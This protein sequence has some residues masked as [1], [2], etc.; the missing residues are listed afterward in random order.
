MRR[1]L[2]S[3]L[4]A[5][6]FS[7]A[8]QA[9]AA[10]AE[11]LALVV[12]DGMR[13][14]YMSLASMPN[15]KKLIGDGVYYDGAWV[16]GVVNNTPPSHA[17]ISTGCFTRTHG[18]VAFTWKDPA[19]NRESNLTRP[20]PIENGE[21][22]KVISDHHVPSIAKSLRERYPDARTVAAGAHKFHA[23]AG[24]AGDSADYSIFIGGRPAGEQGEEGSST[25]I[26]E[27]DFVRGQ[28]PPAESM[29]KIM[30][31]TTAGDDW[32]MDAAIV[33]LNDVKPRALLVNL[34]AVDGTGHA[35]GGRRSPDKMTP[36]LEN[37]DKQVGKLIEAYKK[38]GI[39]DKTVFVVT[40]DH[41]MMESQPPVAWETVDRAADKAAV[42]IVTSSGTG[43]IWISDSSKSKEVVDLIM[44]ANPP[45][46]AAGY[47]KAREGGEFV[48]K[49]A[50]ATAKSI[51][52][53]LAKTYAYLMSTI[54]CP[55]GPDI[56][57]CSRE[58]SRV[59]AGFP[60]RGKHYQLA[61]STQH[62][63]MVFAGPG[64][65]KG[66]IS[67]SPARLVDIAPTVLTLLGV[68]PKGMD[69][70]P[71]ADAM[72][73]P[74]SALTQAQEQTNRTLIP[75]RDALRDQPKYEQG[76]NPTLPG[77]ARAGGYRP[78]SRAPGGE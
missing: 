61:W 36:V 20:Q 19:T 77:R 21:F 70:L 6:A 22:A 64:V 28:R 15:L 56:F 67:H 59:P 2:L 63:P 14:D 32:G 37:A 58:M 18:I 74:G 8:C 46:A 9:F 68:Q 1:L 55:N 27:G 31:L 34:P 35:V 69:G 71:L 10:P 11:Y 44:A 42:G 49:P 52:P 4:L 65:R 5:G 29:R 47:Y 30:A 41:G 25:D 38:L 72:K 51:D 39:Y 48:Y 3:V 75:L 54:A 73:T 62:I 13:P 43:A 17:S 60:R 7:A 50:D 23:V 76:D 53:G 24:L 16:G 12:I 78:S 33:M 40:A 57:I 45:A 66:V 26:G